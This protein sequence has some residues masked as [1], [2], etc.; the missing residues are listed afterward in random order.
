MEN[1]YQ[2]LLFPD[3]PPS[4]VHVPPV[5]YNDLQM[6]GICKAVISRYSDFD[7][8]KYFYTLPASQ[9]VVTYRQEI[10]RDFE[11]NEHMVL[12]IKQYTNQLLEAE[13]SYRYYQQ[14]DDSVKRGSYLLL[15][16]RNYIAALEHLKDVLEKA[17]LKSGGL[18][19]LQ[20][21]LSDR[22]ADASFQDFREQVLQA[23][24]YMEQ[25]QLMLLIKEHEISVFEQDEQGTDGGILSQLETVIQAFG[26]S[27]NGDSGRP[28]VVTNLFPAPLETSAFEDAVVGILKKSRPRIFTALEKF[29]SFSFD[30]EEDIFVKRKDEFIFYISFLEF[31]QQLKEVGYQLC[32]PEIRDG[33]TL[34]LEGVYDLALAWK[35]R[36][37]DYNI[38]ENDI[39]FKKDKSFLVIT[40]PN[41]GGKTT[42]ARA[43]GQSVLFMLLGLKAPCRVMKT[44]FFRRILTHFEVEESVET[45]AGKL[46]EELQRLKPMM[47]SDAKQSFVILNELFTTATTYD[48]EIMAEKV[49]RHFM[50]SGCMGIYVTHIQELADEESQPGIQSMVAQ[51]DSADHSVRTYKIIPMRAEGL[52][53]S[54]SIAEKYGL[55]YKQVTERISKL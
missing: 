25:L 24:S 2:S 52:G 18:G 9:S 35:N 47:L 10:Y 15:T 31:E 46:K 30:F 6:D 53:Y 27:P 28:P 26:V 19:A 17:D 48:A 32:Y 50:D 21:Y 45:G 11:N 36:F 7:I 41:Q 42:L 38:V 37:S 1:S 8:R 16:C 44:R 14:T 51:V 3:G 39:S 4:F 5:F 55:S 33:A 40:G 22:L 54:D 20:T 49:M 23:F 29:S 13:K 43:A 12:G 34:E